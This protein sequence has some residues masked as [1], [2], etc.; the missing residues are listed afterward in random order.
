MA[1]PKIGDIWKSYYT[2]DRYEP[3]Y[4]LIQHEPFGNA[5]HTICENSLCLNT[6]RAETFIYYKKGREAD[7]GVWEKQEKHS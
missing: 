3:I 1:T 4:Y 6:G 5:F 7:A 2:D